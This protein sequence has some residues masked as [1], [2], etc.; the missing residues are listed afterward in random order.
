MTFG[1]EIVLVLLN[2]H[3]KMNF[4]FLEKHATNLVI[5]VRFNFIDTINTLAEVFLP[6][7]LGEDITWVI[8][9]ILQCD[10]NM[11]LLVG[12][13]FKN[14]INI[15]SGVNITRFLCK[16]KILII[17][18]DCLTLFNRKYGAYNIYGWDCCLSV[19]T[20]KDGT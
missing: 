6:W 11:E 16:Y 5:M 4:M 2:T 15:L 7:F 8:L 1:Q 3:T 17:V 19:V 9:I 14:V 18:D 13:W 12:I 20:D 10:A